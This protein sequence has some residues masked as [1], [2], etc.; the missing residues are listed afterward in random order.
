MSALTQPQRRGACPG[1]S[2]PMQ[3]GDGLL[4]RILPIGTIPLVAFSSLCS[5]AKTYG[6]GVI[7]V[8]S[9]GSIQIRG[10]NPASTPQFATAIAALGIAAEDGVPVL[11]NPLAGLDPDE[12]LDA[13]ALAADLRRALVPLAAKLAPK[14]SVAIDGP[15]AIGLGEISADVRLCAELENSGVVF[16]VAI[17]GD[18]GHAAPLGTVAAA[19]GVK[20]AVHLLEVLARRGRA[21][22]AR[23][24]I[25]AE[26]LGVFREALSS[27]QTADV[28]GRDV[29]ERSDAVLRTTMPRHDG[30]VVRTD[31]IG[32][33]RLRG[34]LFAVGIGPAFG[35][36]TASLLEQLVAAAKT[37]GASGIR[38]A[39]RALMTIGLTRKTA[40]EFTAVAEQ[41]GFIVR[42]DDPRR[43]IVACAG[44][45]ICASAKIASRA[46]A[47]VIADHIAPF[48]DGSVTIHIS[49]C[50]KG[51]AHAASAALTVVGTAEGCA[52]IANGCAR[53]TPLTVVSEDELPAAVAKMMRQGKRESEHV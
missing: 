3:T 52:L 25:T 39:S 34:D 11:S 24:V 29:G 28:D 16:R 15:G 19:H 4:V 31:A 22:R 9:R 30:V 26:G 20:A 14:T 17:G 33:H 38:A 27:C 23:D 43:R 42:A 2:A 53:D 13:G 51:C 49:G 12:I 48:L 18:E 8:T 1:L 36:A 5:A 40:P 44:A 41:L 46:I 35:H 47:P 7:E 10:L 32:V 50:A 6:N 37:A 21:T 45:P